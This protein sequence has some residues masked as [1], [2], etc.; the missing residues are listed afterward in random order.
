[1]RTRDISVL[2]RMAMAETAGHSDV[3][4]YVMSHLTQVK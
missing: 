2:C 4:D 1:M 3:W